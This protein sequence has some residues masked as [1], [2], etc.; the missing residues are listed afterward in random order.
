MLEH[1]SQL[2]TPRSDQIHKTV[3]FVWHNIK[4][5]FELLSL[6]TGRLHIKTQISSFLEKLEDLAI[7][8]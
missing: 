6:K 1:R 4:I 8:G 7:I 5:I 3:W 2:E